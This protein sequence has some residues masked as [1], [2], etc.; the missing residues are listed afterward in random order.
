[1]QFRAAGLLVI[2]VALNVFAADPTASNYEIK[3]IVLPGANGAVTLDYFAY[4]PAAGNR[5]R[6]R[7]RTEDPA[8]RSFRRLRSDA[9]AVGAYVWRAVDGFR[10]GVL[11]GRVH[12]TSDANGFETDDQGRGRFQ[13]HVA[14]VHRG[15]G[16]VN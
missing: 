12:A 14:C 11:R 9:R 3:S 16:S 15:E 7:R 5:L 6:R 4:D 2:S 10:P 8:R 1:M 13:L